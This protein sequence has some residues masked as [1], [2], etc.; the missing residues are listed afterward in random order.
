MTRLTGWTLG[1]LF[2]IAFLL[3]LG[4][5]T[6]A[7][8]TEKKSLPPPKLHLSITTHTPSV[9][10]DGFDTI[11]Y[12]SVPPQKP[13]GSQSPDRYDL[14]QSFVLTQIVLTETAPNGSSTTETQ[15]TCSSPGY[16]AR[17]TVTTCTTAT[18][19]FASRVESRAYPGS[20]IG[21]YFLGLGPDTVGHWE[22]TFSVKGMYNNA[23]TTLTAHFDVNAR[24]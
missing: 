6:V 13:T 8:D 2:L 23:S 19:S 7:A 9:S 24:P 21:V 17:N 15:V 1:G 3:T 16:P 11:F 10:G 14:T 12:I 22:Y 20:D 18:P 5:F 4:A